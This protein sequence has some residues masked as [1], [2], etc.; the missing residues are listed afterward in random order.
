MKDKTREIWMTV[1]VILA[2]LFVGAGLMIRNFVPYKFYCDNKLIA[3]QLSPVDIQ[4][5]FD[6]CINRCNNDNMIPCL[7]LCVQIVNDFLENNK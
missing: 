3:E 6:K 2:L 1:G 7:T 5:M 4:N